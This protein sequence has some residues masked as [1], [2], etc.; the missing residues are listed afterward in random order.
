VTREE[1]ADQI[2][3]AIGIGCA[4]LLIFL[5]GPEIIRAAA[6]YLARFL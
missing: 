3:R 5:P 4:A 2:D 1:N 6:A